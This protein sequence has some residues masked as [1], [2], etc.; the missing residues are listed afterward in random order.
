[1]FYIQFLDK[2]IHM[3]SPIQDVIICYFKFNM[4]YLPF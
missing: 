4:I 2:I 1:M 3:Y